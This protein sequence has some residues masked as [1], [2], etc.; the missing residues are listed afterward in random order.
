MIKKLLMLVILVLVAGFALDWFEFEKGKSADGKT[1][2]ELVVD[3]DKIGQ[4]TSKAKEAAKDLAGSIADGTA[5]MLGDGIVEGTVSG[6][7]LGAGWLSVKTGDG[8][9]EVAIDGTVTVKGKSDDASIESLAV[10]E[11]VRVFYEEKDGVKR[12]TRVRLP[13][14]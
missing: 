11:T 1:K 12:A 13:G 7:D 4:D 14:G 8:I 2:F 6:V 3:D 5:A 10:G 9:V